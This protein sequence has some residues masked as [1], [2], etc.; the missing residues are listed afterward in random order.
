MQKSLTS[1]GLWQG[2]RNLKPLTQKITLTLTGFISVERP[3]MMSMASRPTECSS[4]WKVH[5]L[6]YACALATCHPITRKARVREARRCSLSPVCTRKSGLNLIT[7]PQKEVSIY[8]PAII[9]S[10]LLVENLHYT[11]A[12]HYLRKCPQLYLFLIPLVI[13]GSSHVLRWK[14]LRL[15]KAATCWHMLITTHSRAATTICTTK[16]WKPS[17]LAEAHPSP[18]ILGWM[19]GVRGMAV[20]GARFSHR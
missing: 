14:N 16:R 15:V 13:F 6:S 18:R 2:D 20:H 7:P 19:A 17:G 5:C 12:V 1:L 4:S 9:T 3:G 8:N 10:N 11:R